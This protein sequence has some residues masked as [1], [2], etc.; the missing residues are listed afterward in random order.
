MNGTEILESS[1]ESTKTETESQQSTLK[2]HENLELY[3]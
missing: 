1:F 2:L 3:H